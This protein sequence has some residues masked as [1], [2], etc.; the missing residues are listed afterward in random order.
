[1]KE[2]TRNYTGLLFL[3]T[4][5]FGL[6]YVAAKYALQGLGVFQL[7]FARYALA[8]VLL[9]VIFWKTR[10]RFKLERQDWKYFLLL[11]GIEPIGYF[12]LE[13]YGIRYTSPSSTS[14]IIA[15][16]P[17][18]AMIF[19]I[20]I[21]KEKPGWL[22][23][24]GMM[25]SFTG[26]YFIVRK[27]QVSYLASNP[28]LGNSLTLLAAAAAGL[29]NCVA[30][31]LTMKYKPLVLTYYQSA[32]ASFFFLPLGIIEYFWNPQSYYINWKIGMSILY[33]SLG[34][35]IFA[36]FIL[37]Y[38]LS[39][40][41]AGRVAIF[42]NFIPVVTIF[43]SYFFF[44]ERLTLNQW[45]GAGLVFIGVMVTNSPSAFRKLNLLSQKIAGML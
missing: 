26:I 6:T 21:L 27:Q 41:E 12:I 31:K 33:L 37:N 28:L 15:T 19:A 42:S 5:L 2:P 39:K 11:T 16:I 20:F 34:A 25:I 36:Y 23:I 30:R 10:H 3:M 4:I 43:A 45:L 22:A 40:L 44:Q 32:A 35:S 14:L 7:I 9:T 38:A 29:Y 8:F 13:T 18:F 1:M 24:V 17:V